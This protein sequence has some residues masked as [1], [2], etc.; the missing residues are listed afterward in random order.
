M[1][2]SGSN[3]YDSSPGHPSP[4]HHTTADRDLL[5]LLWWQL[6]LSRVR[7]RQGWVTIDVE[8]SEED[9]ISIVVWGGR[10]V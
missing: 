7:A 4:A 3:D 9:V 6:H 8:R 1:H 2:S 5:A 10:V